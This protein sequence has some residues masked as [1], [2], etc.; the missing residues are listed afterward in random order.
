MWSVIIYR[1]KVISTCVEKKLGIGSIEMIELKNC[2]LFKCK[3]LGLDFL[4]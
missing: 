3:F 4:Y 2:F 1:N